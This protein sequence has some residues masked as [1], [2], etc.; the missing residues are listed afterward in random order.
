MK[1]TCAN[2]GEKSQ[3]QTNL[4]Q[5]AT[6]GSVAASS[7]TTSPGK[8]PTSTDSSPKLKSSKTSA[9]GST[10]KGKGLEPYWNELCAQISSQLLLPTETDSPGLGLNSLSSATRSSREA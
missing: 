4:V 7:E 10:T 5:C 3:G 2:L 9:R 1:M 8:W 6:A